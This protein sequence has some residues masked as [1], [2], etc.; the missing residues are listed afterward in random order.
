MAVLSETLA[1]LKVEGLEASSELPV[2]YE[3]QS[4]G[5]TEVGVKLVK[6]KFAT[7]RRCLERTI[8]FR[9]PPLHP[10][11]AWMSMYAAQVIT[12][13]IIGEDGMSAYH[14]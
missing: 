8:G 14:R 12:Y 2:P 1:G 3:P 9:I 13:C 7:L 5:G 6:N 10:L 4:N 11:M